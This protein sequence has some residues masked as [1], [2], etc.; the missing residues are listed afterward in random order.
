MDVP[1]FNIGGNDYNVKDTEARKKIDD[2]KSDF[3]YTVS[4]NIEREIKNT[5]VYNAGHIRANSGSGGTYRT[6][7]V[8]IT[9]YLTAG[10]TY[11]ILF[12]G[13]VGNLDDSFASIEGYTNESRVYQNMV[14]Q[15]NTPI[16]FFYDSS[17]DTVYIVLRLNL[18][19]S[20]GANVNVDYYNIN[21][22]EEYPIVFNES[23]LS[24]VAS[25]EEISTSAK[26][27]Y[28]KG[29]MYDGLHSTVHTCTVYD[30]DAAT[31]FFPQKYLKWVCLSAI[32]GLVGLSQIVPPQL[33]GKQFS[34]DFWVKD[35]TNMGIRLWLIKSGGSAVYFDTF[36]QSGVYVGRVW[37][38]SGN[39]L[40][41]DKQ[42]GEWYH[43]TLTNADTD[44]T[45]III[46]TNSAQSGGYFYVS[47]ARLVEGASYWYIDYPSA[48]SSDDATPN[49]IT[50]NGTNVDITCGKLKFQVRHIIDDSI[51]VNC[52]RLYYGYALKD[53][54]QYTL[55]GASDAD[56]VVMLN[57]EEDFLGGYHGDEITDGI[58]L[59][60]DGVV[61]DIASTIQSTNFENVDI[62]V[63][64]KLY[65]DSD[66]PQ[67][68]V[69]C[70]TREKHIH[71][72]KDKLQLLN[73][74]KATDAVNV[75]TAFV[76]MFSVNKVTGN[77]NNFITG[78]TTD[79]D[80]QLKNDSTPTT[81]NENLHSATFIT[82][83]GTIKVSDYGCFGGSYAAQ[84]MHYS[85]SNRLKFYANNVP[86]QINSGAV[87][88]GG[89]I[90]EAE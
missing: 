30:P 23:Y 72:E 65:H 74:W 36:S 67:A 29:I 18:S 81:Y 8:D 62:F 80:A 11:S 32:S 47:L 22:F 33:S 26:Y 85:D 14:S 76:G 24:E 1:V 56:G 37:N 9:S 41:I 27:N 50:G 39:I 2:L 87:F 77:T 53:G 34:Y 70:F 31:P 88:A 21:V 52:W 40:S 58:T 59:L 7:S 28:C 84:V 64:S 16:F 17:Y 71:F 69:Q 82:K 66:S 46:G 44:I 51:N 38:K 10:K 60:I 68:G 63:S 61:T 90:L 55:W 35:I 12:G 57:G 83:G 79:V 3:N 25:K 5:L 4:D 78:Y 20:I 48:Y 86:G 42:V 54:V 19:T 49:I 6:L 45:Q 13:V 73:V 89:Y 15:K 43:F 75:I